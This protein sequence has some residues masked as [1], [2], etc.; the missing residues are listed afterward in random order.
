MRFT[1]EYRFSGLHYTASTPHRLKSRGTELWG[2]Y[3]YNKQ[4]GMYCKHVWSGKR[5][6]NVRVKKTGQRIALCHSF[7]CPRNCSSS[8]LFPRAYDL[9]SITGS[10]YLFIVKKTLLCSRRDNTKPPLFPATLFKMSFSFLLRIHNIYARIYL[11]I[12]GV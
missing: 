5:P 8:V 12:S 1:P 9:F 2:I 6:F 7:C 11:W 3:S 10:C 4:P